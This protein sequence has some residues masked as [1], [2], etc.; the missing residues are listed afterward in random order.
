MENQKL[1]N[2]TAVLI[3][4]ILSILTC[5]CYGLFGLALAFIGLYLTHNDLKTY[6]AA[7]ERFINFQQLNSI[8]CYYAS[9]FYLDN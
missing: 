5:C 8:E 9:L 3:L 6:N 4:G 1:P 2:A 7:P